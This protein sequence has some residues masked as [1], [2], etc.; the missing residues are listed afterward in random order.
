MTRI[1]EE[2]CAQVADY[3]VTQK[4]GWW[5]KSL[6]M[7]RLKSAL[8][9]AGYTKSFSDFVTEATIVAVSK[10]KSAKVKG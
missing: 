5:R 6:F 3:H 1:V 8:L 10:A 9:E 2:L 7:N 4:L